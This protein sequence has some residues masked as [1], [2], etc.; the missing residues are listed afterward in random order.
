GGPLRAEE[1]EGNDIMSVPAGAEVFRPDEMISHHILD[2]RT[3]ELPFVG[4]VQLPV[5]HLG[6][7]EL[8]ITKYVVMMRIASALILLVA[9]L[10]TRRG[11]WAPRRSTSS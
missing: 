10:A 4:D 2:S 11:G 6:R 8:P 3:L 5:L 1:I 9:W 7:Y